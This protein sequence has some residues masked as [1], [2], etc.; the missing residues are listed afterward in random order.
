VGEEMGQ[1]K[2]SRHDW[3]EVLMLMRC[4]FVVSERGCVSTNPRSCAERR[5]TE[6]L[7]ISRHVWVQTGDE[8]WVNG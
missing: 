2:C 3:F 1:C 7:V 4:F 6:V 5:R 8:E